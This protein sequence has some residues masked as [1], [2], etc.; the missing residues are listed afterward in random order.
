MAL[1][2]L[3]IIDSYIDLDRVDGLASLDLHFSLCLFCASGPAGLVGGLKVVLLL[4]H[5][6]NILLAH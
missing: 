2:V 1:L 3:W 6:L 4:H 5:C